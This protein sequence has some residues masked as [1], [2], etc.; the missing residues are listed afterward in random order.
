MSARVQLTYDWP[1]VCLVRSGFKDPI[2]S[3]S[4]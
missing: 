4:L 1:E 2:F 3:I